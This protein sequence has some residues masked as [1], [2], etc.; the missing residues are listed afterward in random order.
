MV[1]KDTHWDMYVQNVCSFDTLSFG[2][3]VSRGLSPVC[4]YFF[5]FRLALFRLVNS[6]LFTTVSARFPAYGKSEVRIAV[7]ATARAIF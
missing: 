1:L 7:M 6:V 3:R 5:L 4:A 2:E